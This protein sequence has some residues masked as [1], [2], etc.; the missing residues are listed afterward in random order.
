M[1]LNRLKKKRIGICMVVGAFYPEISGGAIQCF[2]FID[3]LKSN[4]DFYVIATYKVSS[5]RRNTNRI[6]TEEILGKTKVFRINLYPGKIIPEILSLLA[7]FIIFFKIKNK[8]HIFHMIGYTRKSYLITLLAKI[9][10]T[11]T[12]VKTTSFGIDDPLSIKK[13]SFIPSA[14]YSLVD[15]YVVTSPAQQEGYK[16][17][18]LHENKIFMIPNGVNL[19]RFNIPC[20][21][22]KLILR[23]QMGIPDSSDV[24]LSVSFFSRDKGV[25]IFAEALLLL[26][27]DKLHSIF[28]IFI[29]SRDDKEL[30]VDKEVVEKVDNIIDRLDMKSKCLFID[31]TL[32]IDKYFKVSDIFILPSKREGLPNA[33]LE[34][35]GCGLCC[36]ANRLQGIM[37]YIID[38]GKNGYLLNTLDPN[39]IADILKKTIGN[40][41][42]Q[43]KFGNKAHLKVQQVFNMDWVKE[44]Y[45]KLYTR[46]LEVSEKL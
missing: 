10:R 45:T 32:K 42:L 7:I 4:F 18:R 5:K 14:L 9:Y 30:E 6:F 25:D 37:D 38:S 16:V 20:V 17:S 12:I 34:A 21:R 1:R 11:K 26:P 29:G 22:E 46:L 35:M 3:S 24:I 41:N 31:S 44:S 19:N 2:N 8:V 27:P 28:L 15:A 40:K 33:L 13:R 39:S 43:D 23:Q 36:I